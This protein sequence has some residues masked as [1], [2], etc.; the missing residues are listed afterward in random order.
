MDGIGFL[1][2]GFAAFWLLLGG[3]VVTLGWRQVGLKRQMERLERELSRV[4][5]S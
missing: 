3:Y 1:F 5:E 2:A 4:G